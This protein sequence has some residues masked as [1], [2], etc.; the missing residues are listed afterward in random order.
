M[1]HEH[2]QPEANLDPQDLRRVRTRLEQVDTATFEANRQQL[3]RSVGR[4]DIKSFQRL[5]SAAAA[6]RADWVG[7]ALHATERSH[8]PTEADIEKLARLRKTYEELTAAYEA[9][10]RMVE[11]GYLCFLDMA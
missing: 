1:V 4:V 11:R 2:F 6:A 3:A 9:L 5:A 10:R 8:T 7:A